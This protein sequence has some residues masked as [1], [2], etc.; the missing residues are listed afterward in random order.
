MPSSA[1]GTDDLLVKAVFAWALIFRASALSASVTST[2]TSMSLSVNVCS[3]GEG[4]DDGGV[5]PEELDEESEIPELIVA[6]PRL[7][8]LDSKEDTRDQAFRLMFRLLKEARVIV[9]R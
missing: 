7:A 8:A 4:T 6:V 9:S 5:D 1:R 2:L 3:S